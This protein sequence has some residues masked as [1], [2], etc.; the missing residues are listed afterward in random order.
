MTYKIQTIRELNDRFRKG[1]TSISG[2]IVFTRGIN[3]LLEEQDKAPDDLM[4]LVRSYDSFTPENDPHGEHD[5]GSFLFAG[6]TTFWKI[7]YYDPTLKWGSD[8]PADNTKT[9][10]VLTVMLAEEY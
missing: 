1:D 9:C 4:H 2:Q 8:N 6:Y 7:D 10:R 3:N 5:F